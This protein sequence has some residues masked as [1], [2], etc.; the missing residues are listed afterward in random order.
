MNQSMEI[1]I[2][3]RNHNSAPQ[4]RRYQGNYH[5]SPFISNSNTYPDAPLT[6]PRTMVT[7]MVTGLSHWRQTQIPIPENVHIVPRRKQWIM[8]AFATDH[9]R[10]RPN[11]RSTSRSVSSTK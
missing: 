5:Y 6:T 9:D 11:P 1:V 8:T 4:N 2:Y 3:H 7:K 10:P